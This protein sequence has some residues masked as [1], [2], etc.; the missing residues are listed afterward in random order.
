MQKTADRIEIVFAGSGGQGIKLAGEI[1]AKALIKEGW[2]V[3]VNSSYGAAARGGP[4]VSEIVASQSEIDYPLVLEP[5]IIFILSRE[6]KKACQSRWPPLVA[7]L[8][9]TAEDEIGEQIKKMAALAGDQI[10][11]GM[12]TLGA[13]IAKHQ[14]CK[15]E[16]LFSVIEEELPEK[17]REK[18]KKAIELGL[19]IKV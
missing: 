13:L 16:T 15:K 8:A 2:Q 1:L 11:S 10:F 4:S 3:A 19:T 18:N 14:V 12:I 7:S 6:G 9:K 17:Y 5:K